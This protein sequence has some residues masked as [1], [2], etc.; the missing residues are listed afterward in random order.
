MSDL[1]KI[2]E[3]YPEDY[4]EYLEATYGDSMLSEGGQPAIDNMFT[5]DNLENK[6]LV[7]IGFGLGGVACYLAEKYNANITGLEINPWM[8]QEATKRIPDQLKTK[9][10]Y[11]QYNPYK[12]IPIE[13]STIDM[14]YSRGVLTHLDNKINLF[15]EIYRVLKPNGV[16]II[17]DW[18]SKTKDQWGEKLQAMCQNE[19]LTLYAETESNYKKLLENAGFK[20]IQMRDENKNYAKYNQAI[21]DDLK[22]LKLSPIQKNKVF[23]NISI[24]EAIENYQQIVDSIETNELLVRWFRAEK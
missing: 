8:V 9:I 18:L 14:V 7:D 1:Q 2:I 24:D 3:E 20:N 16:L 19:N 4:C 6:K 17:D 11:Q 13:D 21:V 5:Q 22:K 23:E 10:V 12:K 15:S